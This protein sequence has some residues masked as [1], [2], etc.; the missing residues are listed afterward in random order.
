[1]LKPL[2]SLATFKAIRK[3]GGTPYAFYWSLSKAGIH[4]A[5]IDRFFDGAV[6]HFGFRTLEQT[7]SKNL[8]DL[9]DG[10][11]TG[12]TTPL[13]TSKKSKSKT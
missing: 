10:W 1:M 3:Q 11:L 5:A 2:I 9:I 6:A 13:N 12:Y 7:K 4:D 8:Y